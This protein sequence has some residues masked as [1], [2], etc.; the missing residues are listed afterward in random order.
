MIILNV[1]ERLYYATGFM[2]RYDMIRCLVILM[3]LTP[4]L[5]ADVVSNVTIHSVSSEYTSAP[6]DLRAIHI[7]DG[8]GL[9]GSPAGHAVTDASGNSWQT[10]SQ[11][12]TGNIQFDMESV[13]QLTNVHVWNLNFYAPYN[14]RGANQVTIRT[15]TN[16]STW[17]TEGTYAFTQAS[18]VAGDLGFDINPAGWQAARYI[19]FQILNNFG[20]ADN[21]GHVGLSE[22]QFSAAPESPTP[23]RISQLRYENQ[24]VTLRLENC[25]VGATNEILR[26]DEL[27]AGTQWQTCTNV[28]SLTNSCTVSIPVTN[29]A[30]NAFYRVRKWVNP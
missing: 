3:A 11:T 21:A 12:G 6:W 2:K 26:T 17:N 16:A 14:G 5:R 18:G 29:S 10:I 28:V 9:S 27:T 23:T 19:D 25:T 1:F 20:G 13:C 15:S 24:T 8:S 4:S 7:V 30:A 22:V